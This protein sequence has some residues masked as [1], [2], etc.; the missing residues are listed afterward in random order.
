MLDV[1]GQLC[2][3]QAQV[4]SSAELAL[5]ARTDHLKRDAVSRAL[6]RDRTLVKTWAMRGTLHLLPSSELPMWHAALGTSKRY[7][8]E[9]GWQNYLG[10]SL[11]QLDQLTDAIG[12]TLH[13]RIVTREQLL[14]EIVE[15]TGLTA[16][17]AHPCSWG[18]LFKPAAFKG[19]LCFAP[20]I[21]QRV[22][23]TNPKTWLAANSNNVD[24]AIATAEIARRFLSAYGP[25]TAHD[26]ARWWGGSSMATIRQWIASLGEEA[27]LVEIDGE[28]A[29]MLARDAEVARRLPPSRSVNLLP[30]FDPY[31][32]AASRHSANL[33]PGA[34]RSKVYRPQ[35]WISPVLLAGGFMQG[36]WRHELKNR[37]IQ[38]TMEPF[39][40]ISKDVRSAAE[41]E[42]ERLAGFIGGK[43]Q[44]EWKR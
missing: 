43:L 27:C 35:G 7:R 11:D 36:V 18:T 24:P 32:I 37:T 3:L 29:W 39:V 40:K 1:A 42:A 26:L 38:V 10:I 21:G 12:E 19:S 33:L 22:Q 34:L 14:A 16:I 6:W 41:G 4:M 44:L 23:F 5:W 13:G 20:S 30:G 15:R 28:K 8:S 2:G 31:V 25:A 17:K 9:I